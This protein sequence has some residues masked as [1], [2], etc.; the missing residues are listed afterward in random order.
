MDD[1]KILY[2]GGREPPKAKRL[3]L[4]LPF[5]KRKGGGAYDFFRVDRDFDL[6]DRVHH[7]VKKEIT[8]PSP[9]DSG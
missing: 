5:R 9:K 7:R 6:R 4:P 1:V 2:N 3:L 8:A